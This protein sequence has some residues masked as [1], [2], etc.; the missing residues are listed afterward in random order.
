MSNNSNISLTAKN[1][2]SYA[3]IG[4]AFLGGIVG[5]FI[6]KSVGPS[7]PESISESESDTETVSV[8][9][10]SSIPNPISSSSSIQI[11]GT[12]M[13]FEPASTGAIEA[14]QAVLQ[15]QDQ[16][17]PNLSLASPAEPSND[18]AMTKIGEVAPQAPVVVEAE[19]P[20]VPLASLEPTVNPNV[21]PDGIQGGKMKNSRKRGRKSRNRNTRKQHGG[22]AAMIVPP[23]S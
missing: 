23:S 16:V 20:V 8:S 1:I 12:S 18:A 3:T 5:Y 2:S 7:E 11:P 15:E 9:E 22:Q 14:Q 10:S 21:K 4:S 13:G 6:G 19:A 17:F